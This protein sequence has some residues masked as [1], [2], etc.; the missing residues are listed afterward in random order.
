[1]KYRAVHKCAMCGDC[2]YSDAKSVDK[3][4]AKYWVSNPNFP[5]E[6]LH[7]CSDGSIGL[8]QFIG[9]KMEENEEDAE[10]DG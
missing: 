10:N 7:A 3:E 4:Y 1:M 8:A 6:I 9:F 2:C 5:T